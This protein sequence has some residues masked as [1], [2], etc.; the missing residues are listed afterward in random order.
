MKLLFTV[1]LATA[2]A[3]ATFA[4]SNVGVGINTSTPDPSAILDV[5]STN[6]GVL[7]PRMSRDQRNGIQ[8]PVSGLMIYQTDNTPGFYYYTGSAWTTLN[9]TNGNT[10]QG[11]VNGSAAGQVYL[12]GAAS[13][14]A[15]QAPQTV[16]GDI[17]ITSTGSTSLAANAVTTAKIAN[18]AVTT[19]KLSATGTASAT[20]YLRG[21]GS[22]ATPSGGGASTGSPFYGIQSSDVAVSAQPPTYVNTVSIN[23]EAG[24]TY[25]LRGSLLAQR[26][27]GA[28]V[29]AA[30]TYRFTYSGTATTPIGFVNYAGS[31][32][33]GTAFNSTG[34]FDTET[35]GFSISAT[36][37]V[38]IKFEFYTLITTTSAGTL[39]VQAA[40]AS[41]PSPSTYTSNFVV[42]AGSFI[43]A[44]P[45]LSGN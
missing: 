35:T 32:L 5:T 26:E 12:T 3:T 39:R 21:D 36:A 1:L 14:Y 4:Q 30:S 41:V 33:P 18:G 9:G 28:T 42:K 2:L 20:T 19:S 16:T 15:P 43:L 11:F 13:P 22:W 10:G 40:R 25:F 45:V 34:T 31:Y 37:S 7:I 23:L 24:K 27:A 6:Q 38:G 17:T 8:N 29:N 44:T